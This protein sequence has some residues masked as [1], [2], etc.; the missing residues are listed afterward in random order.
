M[1]VDAFEEIQRLKIEDKEGL[2]EYLRDYHI[3]SYRTYNDNDYEEFEEKY[4]TPGGEEIAV[5]GHFGYDG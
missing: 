5:F 1:D 3:Y 2:E 4:T